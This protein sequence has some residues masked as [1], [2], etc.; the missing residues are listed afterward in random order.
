MEEFKFEVSLFRDARLVALNKWKNV[1]RLPEDQFKSDLFI[2][3]NTQSI[4]CEWQ[5]RARTL[6]YKHVNL[7]CSLASWADNITDL[8]TETRYDDLDYQYLFGDARAL[9]RYYNRFLLV[10]SEYFVDFC[11]IY[12]KVLR[13]KDFTS[14][15]V[16]ILLSN[17]IKIDDFF[18]FTNV[19]IK[20]K[21]GR[22]HKCNYHLMYLFADNHVVP[23]ETVMP[24]AAEIVELGHLGR[25]GE[26]RFLCFPRLI[27]VVEAIEFCYQKMY[28]ILE[29]DEIF[30]KICDEFKTE[31]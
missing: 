26:A 5:K 19:V 17:Q 27:D 7:F 22:F 14:K 18:R 9:A 3:E 23:H 29:P 31:R 10:A 16:R 12:S 28:K 4:E 20:H 15:R 1:I 2:G 25:L 11:D 24:K 30:D 6:G 21:V 8:L 13:R